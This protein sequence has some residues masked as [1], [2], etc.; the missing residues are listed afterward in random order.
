MA[1]EVE[2]MEIARNSTSGNN[3]LTTSSAANYSRNTQESHISLEPL[4]PEETVGC[5]ASRLTA[6]A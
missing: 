3:N 1:G 5:F 6:L 4:N 2:K